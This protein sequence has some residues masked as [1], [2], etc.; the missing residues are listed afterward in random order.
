M[1]AFYSV[2]AQL[3]YSL[4]VALSV[5]LASNVNW[6]TAASLLDGGRLHIRQAGL[7]VTLAFC[8]DTPWS[9]HL[10]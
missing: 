1:H 2:R 5:G 6:S 3:H 10:S 4:S 7:C 9:Q 8:G